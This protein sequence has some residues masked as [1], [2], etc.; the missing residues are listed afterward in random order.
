MT[1]DTTPK[2]PLDGLISCGS[3]GAPMRYDEATGDHE[4]LY[5]CRQEHRTGTEVR[6][7]AHTTDRLVISNALTAVLTEEG[8][9]TVW[10]AITERDDQGGMRSAFPAEDISLLKED[11]GFFLE[12]VG[13][14]DKARSF[15]ATF[16]TRI[17]L[18]P[19]RAVVQYAL[20]LPSH[21]HLAGATEQEVHLPA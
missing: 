2:T 12:A 7:E 6:L 13:G 10:S 1:T 4:A 19:D 21:S 18:F 16:I 15:L 5:V 20:P 11:P 14:Y 17:K 9:A 3:C 8:M